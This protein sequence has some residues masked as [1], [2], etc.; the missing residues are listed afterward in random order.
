MR[1]VLDDHIAREVARFLDYIYGAEDVSF[2]HV[3]DLGDAYTRAADQWMISAC[4][5]EDIVVTADRDQRTRVSDREIA[6]AGGRMIS[7]GGWFDDLRVRPRALWFVNN[8]DA[9][10]AHGRAMQPGMVWRVDKRCKKSVL[11][12]ERPRA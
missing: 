11:Q 5:P 4:G 7:L 12:N 1:F 6:R 3:L 9:L 10:I 8:A 2:I